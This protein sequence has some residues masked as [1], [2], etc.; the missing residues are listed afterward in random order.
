MRVPAYEN[1]KKFKNPL[2]LIHD[3]GHKYPKITAE[4]KK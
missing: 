4:M 3:E 2:V 1:V